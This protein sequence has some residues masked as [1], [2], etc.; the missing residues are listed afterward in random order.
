MSS[1][2]VRTRA[3]ASTSTFVAEVR[4]YELL[5]IPNPGDDI[6]VKWNVRGKEIWWPAIVI[7]CT[8]NFNPPYLAEGHIKYM[9]SYKYKEESYA[10]RFLLK[11]RIGRLLEH[12]N[13]ND[14]DQNSSECETAS[15]V[16]LD[17]SISPIISDGKG[18]AE[19]KEFDKER[20]EHD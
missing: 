5:Q 7:N 15:W 6:K 18:S 4:Q 10:V 20:P 1:R 13:E 19:D 3:S 2:R 11:A 14:D 16:F 9:R 17:E 12:V 8:L